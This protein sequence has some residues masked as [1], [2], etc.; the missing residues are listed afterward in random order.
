MAASQKWFAA[1]GLAGVGWLIYLLSPILTPFVAGAML[2]YLSDPLADHLE[3]LGLRR[4]PAVLVV[5]LAL[6]TVLGL[7]L[8]LLVPALENQIDRLIDNLP[9]LL[10]W[11]RSTLLPWLQSHLGISLRLRSLEDIASVVSKHWEGAGGAASYILASIS[12]SGAAVLTWIANLFLIPVVT[13]Y[14]LRDWDRLVAHLYDLLPRRYAPTALKLVQEA[15]SVLS[16]FV[17]GQLTVMLS[18]AGIYCTGLWI[19]GLDLAFLIGFLAGVVSFIPYAGTLVGIAAAS[20]AAIMQFGDL[21]SILPVL[22]VFGVGQT[23]EGIVLTPWLVGDRIGL[24][25]VAVIFSVLAGGQL[26]GFLGVLL[27]LPAASVVM[28]LIRHV[29]ELYKD[30]AFYAHTQP[31]TSSDDLEPPRQPHQG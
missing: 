5:F 28:V 27:A 9:E 7:S 24:H 12:R 17:R 11:V 19:V 14:L 6:F 3:R 10:R 31:P 18:L 15:D 16:A 26:F 29:H 23:A 25:P 13:F 2:A 30:S 8:V 20:V 1:F 4:T 22:V 21:W